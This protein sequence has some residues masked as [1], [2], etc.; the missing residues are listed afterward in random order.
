MTAFPGGTQHVAYPATTVTQTGG[1]GMA[2]FA[3]T[4]G[5][6]PAGLLLSSAGTVSGTPTESGLFNFTVT[7]TDGNGCTGSRPYSL[8]L[9]ADA[10]PVI[11]IIGTTTT[12]RNTPV[13]VSFTVSDAET[14]AASVTLSGTSSVQTLVP[15]ANLVFGGSGTNRTLTITP[16]DSQVGSTTITVFANDGFSSSNTSFL[17]EVPSNS[18]PT[19]SGLINSVTAK[20]T[21]AA[22]SFTVGDVDTGPSTVVL[23]GASS[24]PTLVPNA[25]LSFSGS[26]ASRTLQITPAL[27]QYGA[28]T[29]T[30]MASDGSLASSATF[31]LVV[32]VG[33]R[34]DLN[35]DGKADLFWRH[36]VDGQDIGFLM[37]GTVVADS[38]FLP[39]VGDT[40]W[41]IPGL[42]DLNAEGRT[43]AIWRHRVN[44]QNVAWL[45]NGL[46][47]M[48]SA[49]LPTIADTNWEIK[50]MGDVNGDAK[51]DVVFRNRATG[52]NIV[53][54]MDGLS[55]AV[56]A[57]LPTVV[58]TNWE[59]RG[60][61]DLDAGGK[62]DVLWRHRTTGQNL[63]WLMNG[64][65]V[66]SVVFLPTVADTNW[67]FVGIGDLDGDA[68]ADVLLRHATSGQNIAWLMNGTT[69][70]ASAF[71]GTLADTNWEVRSVGDL[72]ADGRADIVWRHRASGQNVAW[73]MDGLT[74]RSAVFLPTVAD[75]NWRIVGQ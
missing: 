28:T 1:I 41:E 68:K 45:M 42:G 20:N 8:T 7:A 11:S 50:G 55:I 66:A 36:A 62:A 60:L 72:D 56:S 26:G 38:A 73:L 49:F 17:L 67:Q 44:G 48:T 57:F 10:P 59:I 29:I 70:A 19:I 25:N 34:G 74:M 54:L 61:G 15:N 35:G 75:V 33:I 13:T 22:V 21:Q 39:T 5:A 63:V 40:N 31:V 3:I 53:W 69:V 30:V 58:D 14:G 71:L 9:A 24:N 46:T 27:D 4:G 51:A 12:P 47:V 65:T 6:L 18:A 2:T 43:D 16:I 37:N 23:S 52:Q 64:V 32:Y